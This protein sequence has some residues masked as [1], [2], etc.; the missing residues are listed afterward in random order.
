MVI[1]DPDERLWMLESNA[2][3]RSVDL[4]VKEAIELGE[5]MATSEQAYWFAYDL[6]T[7]V[8]SIPPEMGQWLLMQ[9]LKT[10]DP[11]RIKDCLRPALKSLGFYKVQGMLLQMF[12]KLSE[13]E[14]SRAITCFFWARPTDLET[15]NG[16]GYYLWWEEKEIL[17]PT[18]VE[19]IDDELAKTQGLVFGMLLNEAN[20]DIS[21]SLKLKIFQ[22]LPKMRDFYVEEDWSIYRKV[23]AHL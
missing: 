13:I 17:N 5:K 7:S 21:E 18:S 2:D 15:G 10:P 16:D 14:K 4:G 3:L 22:F 8:N 11:A 1:D 23:F 20:G 12:P 6:A 19:K 9:T